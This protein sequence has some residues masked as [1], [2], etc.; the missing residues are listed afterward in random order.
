MI[1]DRRAKFA[2]LIRTVLQTLF[3]LKSSITILGHCRK[4]GPS[5]RKIPKNTGINTKTMPENPE[6]RIWYSQVQWLID[7]LMTKHCKFVCK[8]IKEGKQ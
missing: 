8:N 7:S 3:T 2:G 4:N 1:D 6:D 5:T